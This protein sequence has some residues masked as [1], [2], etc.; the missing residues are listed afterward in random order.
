MRRR[1]GRG[2]ERN[3]IEKDSEWDQKIHLFQLGRGGARI[4]SL[5]P[6]RKMTNAILTHFYSFVFTR[7]Y[8]NF[9]NFFLKG[10]IFHADGEFSFLAEHISL[11]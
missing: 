9:M 6:S 2:R 10:R 11:R 4:L 3:K 1:R 8:F 7:F 5:T